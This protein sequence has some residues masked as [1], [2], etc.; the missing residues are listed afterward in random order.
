MR[1]GVVAGISI[2]RRHGQM[3]RLQPSHLE[4]ARRWLLWSASLL[5]LGYSVADQWE[6]VVGILHRY[7]LV[8]AGAVTCAGIGYL[9][10]RHLRRVARKGRE[11]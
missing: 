7:L 4:R 8:T 5:T 6:S 9:T 2:L 10:V 1:R 3:M 11:R